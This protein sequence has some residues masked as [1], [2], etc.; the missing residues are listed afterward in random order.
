M[1]LS[2]EM[3]AGLGENTLG[4][5]S[6]LSARHSVES[7]SEFDDA[8]EDGTDDDLVDL[9]PFTPDHALSATS[10]CR[11]ASNLV[12]IWDF[13]DPKEEEE[14]QLQVQERVARLVTAGIALSGSLLELLWYDL[15]ERVAGLVTLELHFLDLSSALVMCLVTAGT[16]LSKS[17]WLCSGHSFHHS[18][19]G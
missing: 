18:F 3:A 1:N 17:L 12:D 7:Y 8:W 9:T 16:T 19:V 6:F 13:L 14:E 2:P 5:P 10:R 4:V 15:S 11:S